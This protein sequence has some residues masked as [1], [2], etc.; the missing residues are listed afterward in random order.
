M[1]A[2]LQSRTWISL[3]VVLWSKSLA[4]ASS[5]VELKPL[6]WSC[7][8]CGPI[9]ELAGTLLRTIQSEQPSVKVIWRVFKNVKESLQSIQKHI[10]SAY[11]LMLN[12]ENE[13]KLEVEDSQVKILRY[14]PDDE[15]FTATGLVLPRMVDSLLGKQ[16]YKLSLA[17]AREAVI[18]SLYSNAT[19][20][21]REG[22]VSITVE[23]SVIDIND[24]LRFSDAS[25]VD[26]VSPGF[27]TFFADRKQS[28]GDNQPSLQVIG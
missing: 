22:L 5:A 28:G 14:L 17:A 4:G 18:L 12:G 8:L 2:S 27:D 11:K 24:V 13:I 19:K 9:N 15:L 23:V 10:I 25:K 7:G 3:I 16:D 26:T 20:L 1:T 21:S 6:G